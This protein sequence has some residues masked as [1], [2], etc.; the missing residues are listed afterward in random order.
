MPY[1]CQAVLSTV[2]RSHPLLAHTAGGY[3]ART[4]TILLSFLSFCK[5]LHSVNSLLIHCYVPPQL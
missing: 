3:L 2:V 5:G 4:T 1:V